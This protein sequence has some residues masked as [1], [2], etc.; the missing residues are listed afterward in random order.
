MEFSFIVRICCQLHVHTHSFIVGFMI[1]FHCRFYDIISESFYAILCAF[2]IAIFVPA[3]MFVLCLTNLPEI[4]IAIVCQGGNYYKTI[5][6][7]I[8]L[9]LGVKIS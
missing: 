9:I 6:I 8:F 5:A 4:A 1:L 3:Q 2:Y 7:Y